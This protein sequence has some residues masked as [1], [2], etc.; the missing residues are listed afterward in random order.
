MSS[1]VRASRNQNHRRDLERSEKTIGQL[2]PIWRDA[3][4][5]VIDG[6]QRLDANPKWRAHRVANEHVRGGVLYDWWVLVTCRDFGKPQ[7][8]W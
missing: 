7:A 3:R 4:G 1:F 6:Y 5:R 2:Y 8:D